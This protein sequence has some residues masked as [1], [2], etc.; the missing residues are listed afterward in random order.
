MTICTTPISN[1][2][3]LALHASCFPLTSTVLSNLTLST[4]VWKQPFTLGPLGPESAEWVKQWVQFSARG[5]SDACHYAFLV[6]SYR[7]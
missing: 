3:L 1:L 5:R 7:N 4:I 2:L 6:G